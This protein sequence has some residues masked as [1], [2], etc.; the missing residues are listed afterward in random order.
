MHLIH[1]QPVLL[2]QLGSIGVA[3][4]SLL[5]MGPVT[6]WLQTFSMDS[7]HDPVLENVSGMSSPLPSEE[8]SQPPGDRKI[9]V[10]LRGYGCVIRVF[11]NH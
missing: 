8:L 6:L 1:S 10:Q 3:R 5:L 7:Y 9:Q 11:G 2:V 4:A